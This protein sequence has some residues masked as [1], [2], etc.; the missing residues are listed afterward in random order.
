LLWLNGLVID[1]D[2]DMV[3][4]FVATID[5]DK[6]VDVVNKCFVAMG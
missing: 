5:A 1:V 2:V 6:F 4:D 3:V